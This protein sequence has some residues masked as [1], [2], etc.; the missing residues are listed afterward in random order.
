MKLKSKCRSAV[1]VSYPGPG[2]ARAMASRINF[3]VMKLDTRNHLGC[4]RGRAHMVKV[5]MKGS[6]QTEP[7]KQPPSTTVYTCA[8]GYAMSDRSNHHRP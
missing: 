1:E 5:S 3:Q 2:L 8:R 6:V 4:P 7:T